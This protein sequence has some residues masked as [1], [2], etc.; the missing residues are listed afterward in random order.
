MCRAVEA[1]R[2]GG[3]EAA[4]SSPRRP[5]YR[6]VHPCKLF[7]L[8]CQQTAALC[9]QLI[10]G[11]HKKCVSSLTVWHGGRASGC[12]ATEELSRCRVVQVVG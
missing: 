8:M 2:W 12:R 9:S 6:R 7:V 5:H 11:K 10:Q 3:G 4:P 1:W